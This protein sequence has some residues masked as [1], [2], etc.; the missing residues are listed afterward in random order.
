LGN[1]L[2]PCLVR[3]TPTGHKSRVF[4]F[5]DMIDWFK[6][7]YKARTHPTLQRILMKWDYQGIGVYWALIELLYENDGI[8]SMDDIEGHA[9]A[10][11]L[12][13]TWL[14]NFI[15]ECK[16]F[17]ID[18]SEITSTTVV[19]RLEGRTDLSKKRSKA[20]Q[21]RWSKAKAMQLHTKSNAIREEKSREEESREEDAVQ[22]NRFIPPSVD[23][24]NAI[25]RDLT[26]SEKFVDYYTSKGWL[27]GKSPMKDWKS[28]VRNW[29]R[30]LTDKESSNTIRASSNFWKPNLDADGRR[31][32]D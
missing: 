30:N 24:V 2:K 20:S 31:I 4:Y 23:D 3:P 16:A 18:G 10:L 7:D 21:K 8:L 13:S 25:M 5:N 26:Q 14:T 27:V 11:R 6:H 9:F 1:H 32:Y 15:Q 12:D 19:E 22:R 29:K 17:E 28:A